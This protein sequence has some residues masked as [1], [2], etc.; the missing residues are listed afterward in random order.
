[1][2]VPLDEEASLPEEPSQI[3]DS[4]VVRYYMVEA[5][6]DVTLRAH[7]NDASVVQLCEYISECEYTLAY[8]LMH[9][10]VYVRSLEMSTYAYSFSGSNLQLHFDEL[11][12]TRRVS[13]MP[14][15][16]GNPTENDTWRATQP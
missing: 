12:S 11:L 10:C 8:A 15:F 14:L 3:I 5:W 7:K 13:Y 16:D 1:M 6:R 4:N 9:V 2:H